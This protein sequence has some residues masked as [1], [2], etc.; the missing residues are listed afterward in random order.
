MN[1][2]R[3]FEVKGWNMGSMTHVP[4]VSENETSSQILRFVFLL[5]L[6]CVMSSNL[7]D[8]GLFCIVS[9][10]LVRDLMRGGVIS[11]AHDLF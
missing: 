4:D 5:Y 7:Y 3:V 9:K 1:S 6:D 11:T 2:L 8:I 10:Y